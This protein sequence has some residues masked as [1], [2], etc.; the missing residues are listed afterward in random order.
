MFPKS[1]PSC[2]HKHIHSSLK[3]PLFCQN[4]YW[5]HNCNHNCLPS[6]MH[7]YTDAEAAPV[8]MSHSLALLCSS[9]LQQA[10]LLLMLTFNAGT[11]K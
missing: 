6:S 5:N 10:V 3:C 9:P 4:Q 8:L 7:S 1:C 11:N 2:L